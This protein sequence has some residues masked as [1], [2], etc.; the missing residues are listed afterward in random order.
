[1]KLE[2]GGEKPRDGGLARARRSPQNHRGGPRGGDHAPERTLGAEEV[3]LPHHVR[4]HRR[5]QPVGQGARRLLLRSG[6]AEK[7]RHRQSVALRGD[8]RKRAY[9]TDSVIVR[10]P[11]WISRRQPSP[12]ASARFS[13]STDAIRSPFKRRMRSPCMKPKRAACQDSSTPSTTTPLAVK[14][15]CI[16][17]ASGS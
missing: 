4:Q 3:I 16:S 14:S 13:A 12:V 15:D 8:G 1:M 2:G 11:R 17:S 6:A 10:S 7:I 9:C 5:A